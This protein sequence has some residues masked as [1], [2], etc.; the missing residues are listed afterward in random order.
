MK[1]TYG[2]GTKARVTVREFLNAMHASKDLRAMVGNG[3]NIGGLNI[4][5]VDQVFRIPEGSEELVIVAPEMEP[6]IVELTFDDTPERP[7]EE[8]E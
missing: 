3:L 4:R 6:V 2:K 8:K 1:Y 7:V 5:S